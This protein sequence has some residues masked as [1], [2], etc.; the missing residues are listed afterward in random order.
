MP[1]VVL[2]LPPRSEV[3]VG[4]VA[5]EVELSCQYSITFWCCATDDS[6]RAVWQNCQTWKC[7]SSRGVE[8]SSSMQRKLHPLTF[9]NACW[10]FMETEQWM[11]AQCG[12]RL[13]VLAVTT[14]TWKISNVPD[15]HAD[16]YEHGVQ[17]LHHCWWKFI[18]NGGDYLEKAFCS[19][20]FTLPKS[21]IV[22]L[23]IRKNYFQNGLHIGT[24]TLMCILA[25]NMIFWHIHSS[26]LRHFNIN[27]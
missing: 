8:F 15:G 7:K 13:C 5:V 26:Q 12:S 10:M 6:R 23:D 11:W 25:S 16:L 17:A 1:P 19:W 22:L 24:H 14:M 4:G 21:V 18:V 3:D 2:C 20:E 9:I 27:T